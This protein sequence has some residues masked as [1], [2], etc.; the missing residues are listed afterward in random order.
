MCNVKRSCIEVDEM[1]S[2]K[3]GLRLNVTYKNLDEL[4]AMLTAAELARALGISSL[5]PDSQEG[6]SHAANWE[7]AHGAERQADGLD[8]PEHDRGRGIGVMREGF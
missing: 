1:L 7:T 2:R 4:P 3:G 8:Q 5:Y 6:L